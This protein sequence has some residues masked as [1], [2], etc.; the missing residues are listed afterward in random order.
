MI[1][2]VA[3]ITGNS[4]GTRMGEVKHD[5]NINPE[6]IRGVRV[7]LPEGDVLRFPFTLT[8]LMYVRWETDTFSNVPANV[9]CPHCGGYVRGH[10]WIGE[11]GCS[12]NSVVW[13]IEWHAD[14]RT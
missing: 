11:D 7:T 4:E 2:T 3:L 9:A 1:V 8:D 14:R 10:K 12:V 13:D 6:Y 5:F